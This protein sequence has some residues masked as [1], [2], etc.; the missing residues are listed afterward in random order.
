MDLSEALSFN[1]TDIT[2]IAPPSSPS[3]IRN[4]AGLTHVCS[5]ASQTALFHYSPIS[6]TLS[7]YNTITQTDTNADS[8]YI[9]ASQFQT[10][11]VVH[12]ASS[13]DGR[14]LLLVH[15]NSSISCI[16]VTMQSQ[17]QLRWVLQD[18]HSHSKPYGHASSKRSH[19]GVNRGPIHSVSFSPTNYDC[20][21]GDAYN[22]LFILDCQ[23]GGIKRTIPIDAAAAA[24]GKILSADWGDNGTLVVGLDTG[25]IAFVNQENQ[26]DFM[27]PDVVRDDED[28]VNWSCTHVQCFNN[29][30][31]A[32]G[33]C[34]VL[35][36]GED[37]EERNR[38]K[39][40]IELNVT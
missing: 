30:H 25:M 35:P 14:L 31:V 5:N 10:Q 21:I 22:G 32:V 27:V 29:H 26:F 13:H 19:G 40:R 28:D 1:K 18:I 16:N 15:S 38:N 39:I 23:A 37:D 33:L 24:A 34:R 6:N 7:L 8:K 36:E 11:D 3:L 12:I 2:A 20:I 9:L 17:M 4:K